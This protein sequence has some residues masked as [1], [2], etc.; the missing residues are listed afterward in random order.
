[1]L[2]AQSEVLSDPFIT[3]PVEH[4]VVTG[5][6]EPAEWQFSSHE[7]SAWLGQAGGSANAV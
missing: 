1:M 2:R 5:L 7:Q 3:P 6:E 4:G